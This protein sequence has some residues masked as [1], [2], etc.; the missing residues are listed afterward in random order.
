[1]FSVPLFLKWAVVMLVVSVSFIAFRSETTN[2]F[3]EI[4]KGIFSFQSFNLRGDYVALDM[5]WMSYWITAMLTIGF[6]LIEFKLFKNKT[7]NLFRWSANPYVQSIVLFFILLF[8]EFNNDK[9]IYFQ[10]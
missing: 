3:V 4:S 2:Q 5:W 7:E 10:F 9:F 8:G 1:M 6:V